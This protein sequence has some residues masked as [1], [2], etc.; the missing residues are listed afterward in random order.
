[1]PK[2]NRSLEEG[3][4]DTAATRG[5]Y[6]Y[7]IIRADEP[8]SFTTLGIGER[9]D[10]VHTVNYMSLAAV[11]SDSPV[12]TYESNRRNM[13][14][15]TRVMEEVMQ[16]H[17]ILPVR[18][19][20][21][22]TDAEAIQEKVLKR[23]FGGL[24]GLFNDIEDRVELGLKAF[25]YEDTIFQEIIAENQAIRALR[26]NLLGRSLDQT[27]YDRIRLGEMVERIMWE[28]RTQDS[29]HIL[30]YLRP[31]AERTVVNQVVTDRMVINGAFLVSKAQQATFDE[32][33]KA[34]DAEMGKRLIFKYVGPVP[35]YNF[36][37]IV[38]NW[39]E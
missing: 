31:L 38:V 6:L 19:G 39:D 22:A 37:N 29:D 24:V 23:R 33:V 5:K 18:F 34:L 27:Y 1:M 13:M 35:P 4:P 25:W 15:H 10:P 20:T 30:T 12:I 28:K 7:C 11:V 32:A 26:D 14:A 21:V 2:R 36:V 17:A 9:G 16:D 8:L 3:M